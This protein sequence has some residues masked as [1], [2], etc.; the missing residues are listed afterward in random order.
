MCVPLFEWLASDYWQ[1]RALLVFTGS[2]ELLLP[3]KSVI[4]VGIDNVS[5]GLVLYMCSLLTVS[6]NLILTG[7]SG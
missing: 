6:H 3:K 2:L 5:K 7:A 4:S 1:P